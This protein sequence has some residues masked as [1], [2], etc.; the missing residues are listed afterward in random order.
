MEIF[1]HCRHECTLYNDLFGQNQM[2]SLITNIHT[3]ARFLIFFNQTEVLV[4]TDL[5]QVD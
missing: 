2:M 3:M 1:G 5:F 4:N